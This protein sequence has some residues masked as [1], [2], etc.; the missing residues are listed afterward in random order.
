MFSK[1][2]YALAPIPQEVVWDGVLQADSMWC[3]PKESSLKL[4]M[5]DMVDNWDRH[6][7]RAQDLKSYVLENFSQEKQYKAF[8]D[9]ILAVVEA[10][11]EDELV[12]FD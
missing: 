2:D 11:Q 8:T 3:N 4:K 10:P 5:K 6:N 1:I 7:K 12:E 9:S